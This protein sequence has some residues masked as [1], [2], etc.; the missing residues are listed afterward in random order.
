M[1]MNNGTQKVFE[2]ILDEY[3]EGVLSDNPMMA[4]ELGKREGEGLMGA[5]GAAFEKRQERRRQNTL[6]ALE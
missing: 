2:G 1:K 5:T 3:F 4:N 6:A